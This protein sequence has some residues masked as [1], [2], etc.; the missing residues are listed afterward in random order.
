MAIDDINNKTDGFFDHLLP[1]TTI[2]P[3]IRMTNN[4]FYTGAYYAREISNQ[5]QS[6]DVEACIGPHGKSTMTAALPA[7]QQ[8]GGVSVFS[9]DERS[10]TFS[11]SELYP[12]L[13]RTIPPE[14]YDAYAL[15][16]MIKYYF[17]WN[18][19]SVFASSTDLGRSCALL[20]RYYADRYGITILSSHSLDV[21]KEDYTDE[22]RRAKKTGV[23]IIVMFLEVPVAIRLLSQGSEVDFRSEVQLLGGE[24]LSKKYWAETGIPVLDV[25]DIFN[26]FMA[27]KLK[28]NAPSTP[29]KRHFLKKWLARSDTTGFINQ[30]G[31]F[32]CNEQK[33]YYNET[34]LYQFYPNNDINQSPICSGINFT[35]YSNHPD[36]ENELNDI[37]YAYDSVIAT[38]YTLHELIYNYGIYN[39][40]SEQIH[41]YLL[42]NLSFTGL[43]GLVTFSTEL[44]SDNF[45]VGGRGSGI[46]YDIENFYLDPSLY[47]NN[48]LTWDDAFKTVATWN[49]EYGL[50]KCNNISYYE[51][52]NPCITFYFGT[53]S[54][55]LISDSPPP[56]HRDL[57]KYYER[58]ILKILTGIGFALTSIC[59]ILTFIYRSRRLMKMSQPVLSYIILI[60]FLLSFV[61][62]YMI[63]YRPSDQICAILLWFEHVPFQLI[64]GAIMIKCWRVYNITASLKRKKISDLTCAMYLSIWISPIIFT[65]I[66]AT[67]DDSIKMKYVTVESDQY[68]WIL[69][70]YCNYKHTQN[71]IVFLFVYDAFTLFAG[72]VWCWLI[73]K[74]RSTLCNTMVLIKCKLLY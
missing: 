63:T 44:E 18:K 20:F 4:D 56:Q 32:Q 47:T 9:Y 61:A 51:D 72:M 48:N 39:P 73:R 28:Y 49:S 16:W 46:S 62:V 70:A 40:S 24:T 36:L 33:G 1:N 42:H 2:R 54:R 59:I 37:M 13:L 67:S 69:E 34:Y 21:S 25:I 12:N 65:L 10:A 53:Y 15:A 58:I 64:F 6:V 55:L 35:E 31:N 14:Y 43:T 17:R 57:L 7:F 29:L 8:F 41:Q 52:Y 22:V 11:N 23:R 74:V 45:N 66:A 60:G 3:V 19:V 5:D 30:N 38:A 68:N 26:G 71:L 50:P 27:V